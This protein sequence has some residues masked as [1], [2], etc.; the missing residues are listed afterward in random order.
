[1]TRGPV[2]FRPNL[3]LVLPYGILL[4]IALEM[5]CWGPEAP[6]VFVALFPPWGPAIANGA[7]VFVAVIVHF[8]T[9]RLK[10]WMEKLSTSMFYWEPGGNDRDSPPSSGPSGS[11]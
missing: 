2:T 3:G 7:V 9:P 1:M 4:L 10:R 8:T 5:V 6:I 11:S